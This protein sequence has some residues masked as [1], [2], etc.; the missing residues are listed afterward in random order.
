[1]SDIA[2]TVMHKARVWAIGRV[3]QLSMKLAWRPGVCQAGLLDGGRPS[4]RA[5]QWAT[6]AAP[7]CGQDEGRPPLAVFV[8]ETSAPARSTHFGSREQI[9]RVLRGGYSIFERM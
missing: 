2:I 9:V 1:V 5:P 7:G 6:A 3:A 4:L 8:W